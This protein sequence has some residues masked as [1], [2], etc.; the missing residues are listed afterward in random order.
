MTSKYEPNVKALITFHKL[1]SVKVNNS[2]VDD[3]SKVQRVISQE[4]GEIVGVAC[5]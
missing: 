1:L 3:A 4:V 2:T 5:Q